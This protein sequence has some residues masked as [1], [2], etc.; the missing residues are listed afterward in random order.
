MKWSGNTRNINGLASMIML[1]SIGLTT[2]M[3]QPLQIGVSYYPEQTPKESWPIDFQ[4]MKDAGIKR[5]RIGEFAWSSLEPEQG[6]FNWNWLDDAIE[7][8]G[9]FGIQ[10]VLCTP[11]AA[12][13]VWL[14]EK[15]P[16]TLPVN[17]VGYRNPFGCR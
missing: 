13:P 8:A 16:E 12:P 6:D 11:T 10:V 7:L 1:L 4:K 9:D 2:L 14:S 3:A 17:E 15:H 5:I